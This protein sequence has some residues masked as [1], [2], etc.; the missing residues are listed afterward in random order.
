MLRISFLVFT[1]VVAVS[2]VSAQ[3]PDRPF[4]SSSRSR[5]TAPTL[6]PG[7]I[8]ATPEMWFY[9]QQWRRYNDPKNGVRANAEFKS[10]QRNRRRAALRWFGF[11]NSRPTA[12]PDPVHGTYSPR[13]VGGGYSPSYWSG[14]GGSTVVIAQDRM[15]R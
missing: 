14:A 1:L 4:G 10:E 7:E 2:P 15:R 6:S 9:E 11:S 12:S 5:P 13:W 8:Q 3:Q